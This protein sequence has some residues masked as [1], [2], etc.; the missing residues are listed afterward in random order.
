MPEVSAH[1]TTVTARGDLSTRTDVHDL[2][3]EFYR[4]VVLDDVLEPIFGEVAEVDW[5]QHIPRLIDYWCRILFGD[6][7][8]AGPVTAVH[9]HL[10]GL[11][12]IRVEHCDRWYLLWTQSVDA[13]WVGPTAEQAKAHAAALM[14]G[15]AKHIFGFIWMPPPQ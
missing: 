13:R 7:S 14:A 5:A 3:V 1:A 11:E 2:V 10:H 9:R 6:S 12:P 8:Y 4:A 15:M